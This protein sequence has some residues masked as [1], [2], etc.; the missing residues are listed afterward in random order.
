MIVCDLC[1]SCTGHSVVEQLQLSH[2]LSV[3]DDSSLL[4]SILVEINE[5]LKYK[6]TCTQRLQIASFPDPAQLF[7]ACMQY[8]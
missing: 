2:G 5:M 4:R 3:H 1:I 6:L 7:V 8:N